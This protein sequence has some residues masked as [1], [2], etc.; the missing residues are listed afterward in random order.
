MFADELE[1]LARLT[2]FRPELRMVVG[3]SG[4]GWFFNWKTGT[5]SIDGEKMTGETPDYNRG[6][7]LHESAHAAIT[8]LEGIVPVDLLQDRRVFALL[9]VVEDCRIETWMQL[10]FPGSRPW[11]REYNDKLFRPVLEN[12]GDLPP[13]A[14]FLSGILTHWWFGQAAEPMA[15]EAPQAVESIWPAIQEVL[16]ALPPSPESLDG[17]PARYEQS[18]VAQCYAEADKT[19]VPGDYEKAVRLAQFDMWSIVHRDILPVYRRL[20]PPGNSVCLR[21]KVYL[22]RLLEAMPNRQ[23]D[24]S[25]AGARFQGGTLNATVPPQP[26]KET[27]L[28]PDG[29]DPYLRCWREQY[30]AIEQLAETLLRL[31]Q[32]SGR[33][34]PREGCPWGSRLNLRQAMRF[35]VDPR[36]YDRLWSRPLVPKRID[37]HFTLVV[38]RSGSMAGEKIEQ[39]F[40]GIVLLCEACRRAGLP[41]NLYTFASQVE[42][43][44]HHEEAL[45]TVVR[46]RLGALAESAN[47]GTHLSTALE[48]VA[49]HLQQ[50]PNRDRFVFVVSDGELPENDPAHQLIAQLTNDGVSLVGLGLG[51]ETH[52]LQNYFPNSRT[53]LTAEELPGALAELL[54]QSLQNHERLDV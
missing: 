38:D 1:Q 35:E 41:F 43:L 11:V 42:R 2:A 46:A 48:M 7:V 36:L 18:R 12:D 32:P 31:F 50:T 27:P 30:P 8:R 26:E 10:R 33:I 20:L 6:L 45:S 13:A 17:I 9:N 52:Q 53:N 15:D 16:L 54:T 22:S 39:A 28:P 4:S 14:Q 40:K 25:E 23:L 44:L 51:P 19:N 24:G 29:Y 49:A 21:M 37:P 5:I 34:R 47:G 3:G